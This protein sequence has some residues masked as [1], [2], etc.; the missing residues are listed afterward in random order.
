[1]AY[2]RVQQVENLNNIRAKNLELA[3]Y[4]TNPGPDDS[5]SELGASGSYARIPITFAAPVQVSDGSYIANNSVVTFPQATSDWSAIVAYWGVRE[6]A[7]GLI[8]YGAL[9]TSGV[10]TSRVVRSGDVFP[11][12][13][14]TCRIKELD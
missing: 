12:A 11:V 10:P 9:T 14:G 5:G 6:V 4:S 3:L 2:S 13:V 7:G 8:A 1:M